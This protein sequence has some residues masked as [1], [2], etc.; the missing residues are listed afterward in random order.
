MNASVR[1]HWFVE[2][3]LH[4]GH[5]EIIGSLINGNLFDTAWHTFLPDLWRTDKFYEPL[6][7][8]WNRLKI[9]ELFVFNGFYSRR[10]FY[11]II[12]VRNM[13]ISMSDKEFLS[14]LPNCGHPAEATAKAL[15]QS[16]ITAVNRR[17]CCKYAWNI[18]R[19][20]RFFCRKKYQCL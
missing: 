13:K 3:K 16:P 5:Y 12:V 7:A 11:L 15:L 18:Q 8:Q 1:L 6:S 17:Q 14:F 2:L 10:I 9:K 19:E 20:A 4:L